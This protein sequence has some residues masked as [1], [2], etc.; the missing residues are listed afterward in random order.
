MNAFQTKKKQSVVRPPTPPSNKFEGNSDKKYGQAQV[1]QLNMWEALHVDPKPSPRQPII[2]NSP[3]T[4]LKNKYKEVSL[5]ACMLV[6]FFNKKKCI[7]KTNHI[8]TNNTP[9][10]EMTERSECIGSI[11]KTTRINSKKIE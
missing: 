10:Y 4:M 3:L 5:I 11:K 6:F 2:A 8:V 1:Q 9:C 7:K